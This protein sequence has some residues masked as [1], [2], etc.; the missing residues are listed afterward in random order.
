MIY[1]IDPETGEVRTYLTDDPVPVGCAVL[2]RERMVFEAEKGG[3]FRIAPLTHE[4]TFVAKAHDDKRM[5]YNYGKLDS[6][7]YIQQGKSVEREVS[8]RYTL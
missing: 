6:R 5:R 2:D 1:T 3:V 8:F 4:K 7:G